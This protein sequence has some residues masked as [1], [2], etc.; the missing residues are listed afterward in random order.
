MCAKIKNIC[1][2]GVNK[3]ASNPGRD[4][5]TFDACSVLLNSCLIREPDEYIQKIPTENTT[6]ERPRVEKLF[7]N[8]L[9]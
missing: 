7:P 2:V 6:N 1:F 9:K 3:L 4:P 8:S 5:Y